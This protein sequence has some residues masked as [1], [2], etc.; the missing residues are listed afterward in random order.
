MA[1]QASITHVSNFSYFHCLLPLL[2][3]EK[4]PQMNSENTIFK[5]VLIIYP[6]QAIF[7]PLIHGLDPFFPVQ[8]CINFTSTTGTCRTNLQFFIFNICYVFP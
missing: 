6:R 5:G 2:M 3:N 1:G 8:S 4:L 7:K